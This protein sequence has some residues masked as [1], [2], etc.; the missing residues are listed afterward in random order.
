M[1]YICIREYSFKVKNQL[2]LMQNKFKLIVLLIVFFL[3]TTLVSAFSCIGA[4]DSNAIICEGGDTNLDVNY[5]KTLI[6]SS[7]NCDP[8]RKCE[9]FCKIN[10]YKKAEECLP[11]SSL[12]C[13]GS[14]FENA[15]LCVNDDVLL[16]TPN[17]INK[18][19]ESSVICSDRK[20]EWY[21]NEGYHIGSGIN[22]NKCVP[23]VCDGN[24]DPNAM[25]YYL[26]DTG[27]S[28][29]TVK[30][31]VESNSTN[32][33]EY[34]CKT[35]FH[36]GE[37]IDYDKCLADNYFCLGEFSNATLFENDE[38]GLDANSSSVLSNTNTDRK[39]EWHCNENFAKINDECVSTLKEIAVCGTANKDYLIEEKFP[40]NYTFCE[41][42]TSLPLSP[43]LSSVF[44]S[45]VSWKCVSDI[46]VNCNA[47]R[48]SSDGSFNSILEFNSEVLEDNNILISIKCANPIKVTLT[49]KG[50]VNGE[51]Y[52]LS[53]NQIDC[54]NSLIDHKIEILNKPI[55][56]TAISLT[57]IIDKTANYCYTCE[58]SSDLV[59][60]D[61]NNGSDN[62]NLVIIVLIA[63]VLIV[64]FFLNVFIGQ[65]DEDEE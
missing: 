8:S 26:D 10:Y 38:K 43:E 13:E 48:V 20:C 25:M 4:V 1:S 44:S 11:L 3:F 63:A 57:A 52:N 35:G 27:L 37:G 32:K 23:Y 59:I 30:S 18:L 65:V 60:V 34:F 61:S 17:L 22:S 49:M 2:S 64:G 19:I 29:P 36:K 15:T 14:S 42:G 62:V 21:C 55:Q 47:T 6:S 54:N 24:I 31:L 41:V 16:T 58:M 40:G 5:E 33:C 39:C 51:D 50:I 28:G 9:Y 53:E 7:S 46:N 56:E 12:V 45:T